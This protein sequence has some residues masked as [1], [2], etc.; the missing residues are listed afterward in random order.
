DRLLRI[1]ARRIA[2]CVRETD[3]VCWSPTDTTHAC[4]ARYGGDEFMVLLPNIKGRQNAETVATRVL[5]AVSEPVAWEGKELVIT[6]SIGLLEFPRQSQTVEELLRSVAL[7]TARAKLLGRNRYELYSS[8]CETRTAGQAGF[9][10]D[11]H[12]ALEKD[13]LRL[14]YQPKVNVITGRVEGA[15]ALLRWEHSTRGLVAPNEFIP[16]AEESGRIVPFGAWVI[17][18]ACRQLA[19]WSTNG[20]GHLKVAVNVASLQLKDGG[21]YSVVR[22]ALCSAGVDPS[23]LTLELTESSVIESAQ[24]CIE[25]LSTIRKLGVRL[26]LD[27]FGTGYSSL[28]YLEYL[29]I[30]ELK[31]DRSFVSKINAPGDEAPILRAVIAM[32]RSLGLQVVAEGVETEA[33][34]D[35]IGRHSCELYQGYL[36]SRPL[37]KQEFAELVRDAD[38]NQAS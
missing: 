3:E 9:E 32:A 33:Q 11:L 27:D 21:L 18:E 10:A 4:A 15:E 30:D 12:Q 8:E 24:E 26:S 17:H 14:H 23:R 34:L 5:E 35:Y 38:Q 37:P 6:P 13:E 19:Q 36:F 28:S 16:L 7:A 20:W 22:D 2:R 29:P 1:L 31:I 25:T